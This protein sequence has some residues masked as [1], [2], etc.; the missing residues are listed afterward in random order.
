MGLH[1]RYKVQSVN[2]GGNRLEEISPQEPIGEA[3]LHQLARGKEKIPLFSPRGEQAG[4]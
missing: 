2:Q 3:F 4:Q 1:S